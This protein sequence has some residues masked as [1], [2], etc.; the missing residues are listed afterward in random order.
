MKF[1]VM[2]GGDAAASR[3]LG[4]VM[5]VIMCPI[6]LSQPVWA[7]VKVGQHGCRTHGDCGVGLE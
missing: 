2:Q 7:Q 3:R 4:R 5:I 6:E 1:H